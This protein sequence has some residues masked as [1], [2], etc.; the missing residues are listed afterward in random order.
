MV[1]RQIRLCKTGCEKQ[2][3]DDMIMCQGDGNEFFHPECIGMSPNDPTIG[4]WVCE[5]CSREYSESEPWDYSVYTQ[6][7]KE[8][9]KEKS[10]EKPVS[11]TSN[12]PESTSVQREPNVPVLTFTASQLDEA[13]N[14][15]LGD[16]NENRPPTQGSSDLNIA[17][18]KELQTEPISAEPEPIAVQQTDKGPDPTPATVLQ[19]LPTQSSSE[20][21]PGTSKEQPKQPNP[22]LKSSCAQTGIRTR[23]RAPRSAEEIA[24]LERLFQQEYEARQRKNKTDSLQNLS[25][26]PEPSTS[27]E[28]PIDTNQDMNTD[29]DPNIGEDTSTEEETEVEETQAEEA[30]AEPQHEESE[31]EIEAIINHGFYDDGTI[32]YRVKWLGYNELTW[33]KETEFEKAYRILEEYK[34]DK[35]LGPP[36]IANKWGYSRIQQPNTDIWNTPDTVIR[37][38]RGYIRREHR[39]LLGIKILKAGDELESNDYL[40]L[41][42]Y[43]NHGLVGLH[44]VDINRI[45]LADGGNSYIEDERVRNWI[46]SWIKVPVRAVEFPY[47]SHIDHCSSSAVAIAIRFI[48]LYATQ[49]VIP[50]PLVVPRTLHEKLKRTMHK[51][52]S[53]PINNWKAIQ[54]NKM[55]FRCPYPGC[56][57]SPGKRNQ[58][59]LAAHIK[60]HKSIKI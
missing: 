38:V 24:E 23:S 16:F 50:N 44:Q 19:Q 9:P 11:Q 4:E 35:N 54:E 37:A 30:Q 13:I 41:I 12:E 27:A 55:K 18:E 58:R 3:T 34:K 5:D 8:N 52:P 42:D 26:N 25:R 36:T 46:H 51:G 31:Y 40:Y 29:V 21:T 56:N 14:S 10:N 17:Q 43:G 45:T 57:Y 2:E 60:S 20:P 47:Q 6:K 15:I 59:Q 49:M 1:R 48:Q 39:D 28:Q 22:T 53:A 7:A 33:E 32:G